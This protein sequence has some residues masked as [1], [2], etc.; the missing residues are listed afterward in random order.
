VSASAV[1]YYGNRGDE[2]VDETAPPGDDFL[3]GLCTSWEAA[4][5]AAEPI[6]VRVV[7]LRIGV[8]LGRD[9]G[10]IERL[11][12]LFRWGLGGRIGS[13]RQYLSWIHLHD[14]VDVIVAAISDTRLSGAVNAVAPNP[15][16]SSEFTRA[17]AR[18][19]KRFAAI[20]VP[21]AAVRAVFGEASG[22]LLDSQRVDPAVLRA[23]G[24][25]FRFPTIDEAL[26]DI[27]GGAPVAIRPLTGPATTMAAGVRY[28]YLEKRPPAYELRTTTV[29]NAPVAEVFT[30][31]SK[32]ENLGMLT[33][34]A[35]RFSISG[36]VPEIAENT[37][38]AYR[39]R[40]GPVAIGWRSRIV[41][42]R[43]GVRFVDQ[44]E[45]GPYR[46]WW[47]EHSFRSEGSSTVM[48]DRVC[49]APPLSVIGRVAN[50]LFIAPMLQRIF[51]YRAD[52][53]RLRFGDA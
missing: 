33:P 17:L 12:P 29:L 8:V 41:D 23:C 50:R 22:A 47:H 48:E 10:M 53:I 28:P 13:G 40:V 52:V 39:L 51:Q 9:G 34:S 31:F 26:T 11:L 3:A 30:F 43:P 36:R 42:W 46:S 27:V 37:T 20:A 49:Y 45:R 21:A 24:F 15:V 32:P 7:R 44:Q 25:F 14:V 2:V 1:G 19:V 5:T 35:M 16:T 38:I 4:A 18:S 6:G